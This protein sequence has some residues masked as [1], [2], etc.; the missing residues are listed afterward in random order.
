MKFL[1]AIALAAGGALTAGA[2]GA[3]GDDAGTAGTDPRTEPMYEIEV[4]G[5]PASSFRYG[6]F[7][8]SI[9]EGETPDFAGLYER[10]NIFSFFNT[11]PHMVDGGQKLHRLKT[12][13]AEDAAENYCDALWDGDSYAKAWRYAIYD[14]LS[15][16]ESFLNQTLTPDTDV[17]YTKLGADAGEAVG[18]RYD[19]DRSLSDFRNPTSYGIAKFDGKT[20][21][22]K[23]PKLAE[24]DGL[25]LGS[26]AS[27]LSFLRL[28]D[29]RI[30]VGGY[31][32]FMGSTENF[33]W[34]CYEGDDESRGDHTLCPG[35]KMQA[36]VWVIDPSRDPDGAEITGW[37]ADEY[38]DY[39]RNA[40]SIAS[41]AVTAFAEKNGQIYALGYSTTNDWGSNIN[42]ANT[43]VFWK[44]TLDGDKVTFDHGSEYPSMDRPGNN[45]NWNDYT[46]TVDSNLNGYILANRKLAKSRKSNRAMNLAFTKLNDDGTFDTIS[47]PMYDVPF[48]GAGSQGSAINNNNFVVGWCDR[49]KD[50]HAVIGGSLRDSEALFYDLNAM[51]FHY[52]NDFI[53]R[54]DAEGKTDCKASD[55]YY[56]H[57]QWAADIN[58]SNVIFATAFQYATKEDWNMSLNAKTVSVLLRPAAGAFTTADGV[59]TV[60]EERVVENNRETVKNYSMDSDTGSVGPGGL[61]L[62]LSA[63][64]F[65]RA[66]RR[67]GARR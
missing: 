59:M 18:Y 30:L 56:Y 7:A 9:G 62:L 35:H 47:Y 20:Y 44:L 36:T 16:L 21:V 66:R 24:G 51:K 54:L 11:A 22:L 13:F 67:A 23:S 60:N 27:A 17:I 55:G 58:D 33:F 29:G 43:A 3:A 2:A 61:L 45:D 26:Y 31:S 63:L 48:D 38:V 40:D 57:I 12:C 6:P 46:W 53:C 41:G 28:A 1:K 49:R 15:H 5:A 50:M 39:D 52:I 4:I 65:L 25:P 10:N 64:P 34:R 8:V 32:N 14:G 42:P 37:Q 19:Y